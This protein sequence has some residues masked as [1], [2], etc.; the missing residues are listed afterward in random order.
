METFWLHHKNKR[1]KDQLSALINWPWCWSPSQFVKTN[2]IKNELIPNLSSMADW[3][4]LICESPSLL[5]SCVM[6]RRNQQC[7]TMTHYFDHSI[8]Y[9][10]ELFLHITYSFCKNT[11]LQQFCKLPVWCPTSV[12]KKFARLCGAMMFCLNPLTKFLWSSPFP[13]F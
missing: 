6:L 7:L 2:H 11:H 1:M 12:S 4:W 10:E 13:S 3:V 8:W 5:G 9:L